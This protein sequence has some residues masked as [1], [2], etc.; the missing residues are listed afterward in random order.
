MEMLNILEVLGRLRTG[1]SQG[2]HLAAE[3]ETR[4]QETVELWETLTLSKFS[5]RARQ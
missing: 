2:V 3:R 1:S 5:G 4:F